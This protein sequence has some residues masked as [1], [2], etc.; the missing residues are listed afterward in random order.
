MTNP[1]L[2]FLMGY[3][4]APILALSISIIF[5]DRVTAYCYMASA[6]ILLI[7]A[8]IYAGSRKKR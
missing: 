2:M 6:V 1:F 7:S 3:L 8:I 5:G 4:A